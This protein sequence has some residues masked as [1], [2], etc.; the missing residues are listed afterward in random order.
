MNKLK[1]KFGFEFWHPA[2]T[3]SPSNAAPARDWPYAA[4]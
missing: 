2:A 1:E 3:G 4:W